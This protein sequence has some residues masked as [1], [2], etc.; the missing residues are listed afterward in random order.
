MAAD[1]SYNPKVSV[2]LLVSNRSF[3][4]FIVASP[5]KWLRENVY[6]LF[7][8]FNQNRRIEDIRAVICC[9][10]KQQIFPFKELRPA[11][12]YAEWYIQ[13]LERLHLSIKLLF[14]LFLIFENL[15]YKIQ[16]DIFCMLENV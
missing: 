8:L 2:F 14:L 6:K 1:P 9:K 10:E 3:N 11:L 15:S 12:V 4:W 16:P 5:E 7:V 13:T